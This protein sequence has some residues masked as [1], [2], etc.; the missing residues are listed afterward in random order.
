MAARQLDAR[1]RRIIEI[2]RGDAWISYAALAKRVHLSASAVQR[3]VERLIAD[4]VILGAEAKVA[5]PAPLRI[6][7]LAELADDAAATIER[8]AAAIA[9]APEVVEAH[10]VTGEADVALTLEL[11][12]MTAYDAFVAR[13]VNGS[14]LVRRFKTFATLRRLK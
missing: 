14:R 8:F 2:L 6:L 1:D 11:A 13:H 10:Y 12:D 5:V 4:E 3:R 9:G 7:L